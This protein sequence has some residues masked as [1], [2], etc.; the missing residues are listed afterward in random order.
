MRDLDLHRA[1]AFFCVASSIDGR[2]IYDDSINVTTIAGFLNDHF[3]FVFCLEIAKIQICNIVF[4]IFIE[5][6]TRFTTC[7][8]CHNRRDMNQARNFMLPAYLNNVASAFDI[9]TLH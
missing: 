6:F 7:A 2:R 5:N 3:G 8:D 9:H 1:A 4:R